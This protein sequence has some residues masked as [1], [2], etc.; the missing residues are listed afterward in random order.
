MSI[1]LKII[2]VVLPLIVTTLLLTGASSFFSATNA[3][4]GVA[5]EFLGFKA[6]ELQKYANGQWTLLV[7]NN[8]TE[9]PTMV[10]ATKAALQSYAASIVRSPTEVI[11][12]LDPSGQVVMQSGQI[13]VEEAELPALLELAGRGSTDLVTL[14]VGGVSRVAKG[15]PFAPFGW[16]VLVSEA[17]D[18][19]YS[20]IDEITVRT[21]VILAAAIALGLVMIL[22]FAGYLTSPLV[23]VV[24]AME[25]IISTNDLSGRVNVEYP[26]ETGKLAHTFNIMVG[27]LESAYSRIRRYAFQAVVAQ[28]K[29]RRTRSIFEVYV[30]AGVIDQVLGK[31]E[32]A[33]VG[34]NR[35]ISILFSDIRDFTR[36][37]ERMQPD[38]LVEQLNRYFTE[39]VDIIIAKGGTVDKYIGDCIMAF[40][41]APEKHKED[42]L[43]SA[44]AGLE[45]LDAV[46]R[47][48][49]KQQQQGKEPF[50]TGIGINYGVVTVGNIGTD[51]KMNYTII[52]DMVN[53]ASRMESLTKK[54][55]VPLLISQSVYEKVKEKLPC[56]LID[57]VAVKGK[58]K[59][60]RIYTVRKSLSAQE[61][62]AW[63]L[64][65]AA[66]DRFYH[67]EFQGALREFQK[68]L[69]LF[70]D[71]YTASLMLR[72]A[73]EYLR[74]PPPPEWS[75]VTVMT[76]K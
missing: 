6:D 56:R 20:K 33:L 35:I 19:F 48:N 25:R 2:L 30:P 4:T 11:F 27:A 66:M 37:S 38:E 8:M 15:F 60:V 58:E 36:I 68:V 23:R 29:E 14:P 43:S 47:F 52:G 65:N 61:N 71:D 64:H 17:R 53:L 41:G 12:A 1:R 44:L 51:K 9:R 69:K 32:E 42:A 74:R 18:T 57:T 21:A 50:R 75:G 46:E 55:H 59:G 76:E 70:P 24:Q 13:Q 62:E 67:R 45:M 26:D 16:Y 31:P 34:D 22:V 39:L 72:Q 3:I 40:F 10:A 28:K 49:L 5:T 7:E 73:Q 63:S 54:Y